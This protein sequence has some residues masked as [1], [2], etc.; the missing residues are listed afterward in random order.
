[1][2]AAM[3]C[4]APMKAP[5]PPPTMPRRMRRPVGRSMR[6]LASSL[7]NNRLQQVCKLG[8]NARGRRDHRTATSQPALSE[9]ITYPAADFFDENDPGHNV[10]GIEMQFDETVEP[11]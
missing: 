9:K 4:T 2:R 1:M 8:P 7:A 11:T 5:S 3:R 10:P 6:S